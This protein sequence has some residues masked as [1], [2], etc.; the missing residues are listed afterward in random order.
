MY[1]KGL[2]KDIK[3]NYRMHRYTLLDLIGAARKWVQFQVYS[4]QLLGHI[5]DIIFFDLAQKVLT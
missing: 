4:L 5:I 2:Q 1:R 3:C